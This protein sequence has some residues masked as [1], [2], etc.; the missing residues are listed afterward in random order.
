M[1]RII[2]PIGLGFA[3]VISVWSNEVAHVHAQSGRRQGHTRTPGRDDSKSQRTAFR[4]AQFR[5]TIPHTLPPCQ[6][7]WHCGRG[8]L[9][10]LNSPARA[11]PR[12]WS[13]GAISSTV[14]RRLSLRRRTSQQTART[15]EIMY[16]PLSMILLDAHGARS[17]Q[18]DKSMNGATYRMEP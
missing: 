17:L 14:H 9:S 16:L 10:V 4:F 7:C 6:S 18:D 15:C 5:M 12:L 11:T 13:S 8:S 3:A 2:F 1:D